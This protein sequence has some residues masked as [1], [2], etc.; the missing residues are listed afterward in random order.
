MIMSLQATLSEAGKISGWHGEI[1][2]DTHVARPRSASNLLAAQYLRE[3][4]KPQ[5]PG[6]KGG[7]YRNAEPYYDIANIN[8]DIRSFEGPLRTSALR[9]LGAY[10]NIFALESFMDELAEQA[11]KDPVNFRII[12][13]TDERSVAVLEKLVDMVDKEGLVNGEG[14]GYGFS[15]YE[16][17][18][19]YCAV[20]A[21]LT[22]T[23]TGK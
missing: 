14:I 16:N 6:W 19:A 17:S 21:R 23:V 18:A 3:P 11:G 9:S 4:L 10:A 5:P 8:V 15:R 22:V 13:S 1:W 7:T 20:A 2:S 12:H